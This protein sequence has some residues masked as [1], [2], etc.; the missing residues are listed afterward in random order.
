M[1]SKSTRSKLKLDLSAVAMGAVPQFR[2]LGGSIGI[3]IC[4]N[5]LNN[6]ATSGLQSILT[7]EQLSSLIKTAQTLESLPPALRATVRQVYGEGY[8]R[9]MEVLIAFSAASMLATLMMWEKKLRR[10]LP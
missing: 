4:T 5:V 10:Q 7:P 3:A 8:N 9:Q 6:M 2:A 1:Q